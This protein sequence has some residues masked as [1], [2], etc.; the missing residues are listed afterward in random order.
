LGI[1]NPVTFED[2]D[3]ERLLNPEIF[4]DVRGYD[5][6]V[7]ALLRYREIDNRTLPYNNHHML[8]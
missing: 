8:F 6:S 2:A 1:E 4:E 7:D 5:P 3:R